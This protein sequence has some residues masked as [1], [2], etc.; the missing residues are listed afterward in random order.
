[1]SNELKKITELSNNMMLSKNYRDALKWA[2]EQINPTTE[3]AL[4][5]QEEINPVDDAFEYF[6]K[7]SGMRKTNKQ[8]A[9][10]AFR[11]AF[12]KAVEQ[13]KLNNRIPGT[14]AQF[15]EYICK[16]AQRRLKAKQFGFESLHVQTY[17]NGS[18]WQDETVQPTNAKPNRQTAE[19]QR[20]QDLLS[21][22]GDT[23]SCGGGAY[24]EPSTGGMVERQIQR[25]I[26]KQ[27]EQKG[28]T[29]DMGDGFINDDYRANTD[30]YI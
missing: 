18:R 15:A 1:M 7:Y 20:N 12:N 23:A 22:Y 8:G 19:D 29:I 27:V 21:R 4:G 17:L 10:K 3:I 5:E 16:D 13:E 2:I 11:A 14:P 9:L 28:V 25:S 26:P 30:R 24:S 6:W